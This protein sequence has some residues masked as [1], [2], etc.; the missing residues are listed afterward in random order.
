MKWKTE[1]A[2][3]TTL[4][5]YALVALTLSGSGRQAPRTAGRGLGV[6]NHLRPI[7]SRACG[8]CHTD[9]TRWPW[10]SHVPPVSLLVERDVKKGR[11]HLNFSTWGANQSHQ[12]TRNQIQEVCDAVSDNAMPPR[13][14][15]LMHPNARLSQ[16]DIDELCDWADVADNVGF[17]R[18]PETP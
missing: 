9:A 5:L 18:T 10:Y 16:R 1:I 6:P 3:L 17:G 7:I 2:I 15:R 12:P 4:G 13:A 8:D 14:Y 11:E